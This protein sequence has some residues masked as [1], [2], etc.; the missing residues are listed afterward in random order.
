MKLR[1]HPLKEGNIWRA[2][3]KSIGN[4]E[5]KTTRKQGAPLKELGCEW[6]R[7]VSTTSLFL[8]LNI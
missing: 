6:I 4:G 3:T 2:N 5:P 8:F 1:N 7:E